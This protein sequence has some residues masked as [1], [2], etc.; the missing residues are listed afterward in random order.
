MDIQEFLGRLR[1]VSPEGAGWKARCPAHDDRRNPSLRVDVGTDGR[2]LLYCHAGCSFEAILAALG[3]RPADLRPDNASHP[4]RPPALAGDDAARPVERTAAPVTVAALA[5]AKGLPEAFL[6]ENGLR[7]SREGVRIW[8]GPDA[9]ERVRTALRA[10]DGSRWLPGNKPVRAYGRWR[11]TRYRHEHDRPPELML[12]VEGETDALTAWYHGLQALGIPGASMAKVLA[13]EDVAGVHVLVAVR[14]PDEAGGRF[15]AGLRDHLDRIA[16]EIRAAWER[17]GYPPRPDG[18]RVPELRQL[19]LPAGVK[20]LSELHLRDP[21]SFREVIQQ[22]LAAARP[23]S[24]PEDEEPDETIP[25]WPD[26]PEE[27]AYYG[28]PGDVVRALAPFTEGDPVALLTQFLVAF[29]ATVGHGPYFPVAADKHYPNLFVCLVGPSAK[30]RKGGTWRLVRELFERVEAGWASRLVASGLSSGEGLIWH[31]RDPLPPAGD[32]G[33]PADPGAA[34]KR[35]VV[36]EEEFS[37][38]LRVMARDGN[39]LSPTLRQAWDGGELRILT[40][41][42]PARATGAHIAIIGHTTIAELRSALTATD[43]ANGFA[44]RFLWALVRRARLLPDGAPVPEEELERLAGRVRAALAA[45]ARIRAMQRDDAATALWHK[46]Y[47]EL[48]DPRPGLFGAIVARGE[49]QV[50]RLAAVYA[51]T[52]GS[53]VVRLDHLRAAL[54]LW[55]YCED[56]A[57]YIWGARVGMPDADAILDALKQHPEGLTRTEISYLFDRHR[58]AAQIDAALG[59]LIEAGLVDQHQERTAGR[60]RVRY[61]LARPAKK[62]NEEKMAS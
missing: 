26:P 60:P 36:V 46:V 13:P 27:A 16:P 20:D 10:R 50:V 39:T 25:A 29:G 21:A 12:L 40:K 41:N 6:R 28:L 37:S 48:S 19:T 24:R 31:V 33:E 56:S 17:Q 14:E 32:D 53:E 42:S 51:L 7:D 30:A 62:A 15:I 11:L 9:R 4:S 8:Y 45:A 18:E 22:C 5:Q 1:D 52:D 57:R 34:E 44:N 3:L 2:V 35:L 58:T 23:V 47:E 38:P 59:V 54:A 55:R 43:L 49:A 61:R